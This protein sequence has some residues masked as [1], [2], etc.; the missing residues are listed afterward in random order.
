METLGGRP[1]HQNPVAP[2]NEIA[3]RGGAAV[4]APPPVVERY[5]A[6]GIHDERQHTRGQ[7]PDREKPCLSITGTTWPP[8]RSRSMQ[9]AGRKRGPSVSSFCAL[10]G[11][12][13]GDFRTV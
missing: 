7:P 12:L 3:N 5:M 11:E 1:A 13:P 10:I 2:I 8:F 6:G 9:L 4:R